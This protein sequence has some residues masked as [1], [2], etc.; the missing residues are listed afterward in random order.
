MFCVSVVLR[1]ESNVAV[2]SL[3]EESQT[4]L[5][6]FYAN[7][8]ICLIVCCNCFDAAMLLCALKMSFCISIREFNSEP[9]YNLINQH[10][11][12]IQSTT[13]L[14]L[15]AE[16]VLV[17]L[18][19]VVGFFVLKWDLSH[20]GLLWPWT[21]GSLNFLISLAYLSCRQKYMTSLGIGAA[22]YETHWR[23]WQCWVLES[24]G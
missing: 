8:P 17:G 24:S 21:L 18:Q 11:Y 23:A 20:E 7:K 3:K 1:I 13:W 6:M 5:G 14:W 12:R 22:A 10:S 9:N 15:T 16:K 19:L 4:K 2:F